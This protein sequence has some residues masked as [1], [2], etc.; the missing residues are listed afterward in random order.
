MY[1][2]F[3]GVEYLGTS[4]QR[5]EDVFNFEKICETHFQLLRKMQNSSQ[6]QEMQ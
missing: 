2:A 6:I 1:A 5:P 4:S 3:S